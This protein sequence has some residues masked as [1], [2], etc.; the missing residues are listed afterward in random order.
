MFLINGIPVAVV[1]TKNAGKPDGLT[2]GVEQI[3]RYHRRNTG[4][5]HHRA[6][7][8][9]YTTSGL[10][11]QRNMEHQPQ[12]PVQLENRSPPDKGGW[13]VKTDEQ[14]DKRDLVGFGRLR[15]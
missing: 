10:F 13:G 1:E 15:G 11:L 2:L 9:R 3:R 5:V 12:K 6:T 4:D 8:R 14:P 7:L